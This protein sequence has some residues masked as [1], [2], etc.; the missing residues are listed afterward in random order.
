MFSIFNKITWNNKSK[1]KSEKIWFET[2]LLF[3]DSNNRTDKVVT[4]TKSNVDWLLSSNEDLVHKSDTKLGTFKGLS[5]WDNLQNT[6]SVK[7]DNKK[8]VSDERKSINK[9]AISLDILDLSRVIEINAEIRAVEAFDKEMRDSKTGHLFKKIGWFFKRSFQRMWRDAWIDSQMNR[10]IEEIEN[11][12]NTGVYTEKSLRDHVISADKWI[13]QKAYLS[14][15]E[16]INNQKAADDIQKTIDEWLSIDISD[17]AN[18]KSKI[19]E[20]KIALENNYP[21]ITVDLT[22]LESSLIRLEKAKIQLELDTIEAKLNILDIGHIE[23]WNGKRK[24]SLLVK[25][26]DWI[27]S[28]I[29]NY[30]LPD[31]MKKNISWFIQHPNTAAVVSAMLTRATVTALVG[32]SVIS[33]FLAPVAVWALAWWVLAAWRARR[34]MRDRTAQIDR[35]WALW[36]K[37]GNTKNDWLSSNKSHKTEEYQHSAMDLYNKISKFSNLD[38]NDKN[39]NAIKQEAL[40]SWIYYL[41]KHLVGREKNLNML[42]Y[43]TNKSVSSQHVETIILLNKLF[44]WLVSKFNSKELFDKKNDSEEALLTRKLYNEIDNLAEKNLSIREENESS[45]AL[46][47][48]LIYAWVASTVWVAVWWLLH[49]Y[50]SNQTWHVDIKWISTEHYP[51]NLEAH[52]HVKREFW[53]DNKT[54]SPKFD[55]TE[56]MLHTDKSWWWNVSSMLWKTAFTNNHS[57]NNIAGNDFLSHKI[58]AVV[59]PKIW[60]PSFVLPIDSNWNIQIPDSMKWSF[61]SRSFA[62]LE[63][64]KVDIDVNGTIHLNPIATV[65]WH[66]DM[67]FD[68]IFWVDD[69]ETITNNNDWYTIPF[70]WNKYHELWKTSRKEPV[71]EFIKNIYKKPD[72]ISKTEKKSLYNKNDNSKKL[73]EIDNTWDDLEE[74]TKDELKKPNPL[75]KPKAESYKSL[76]EKITVD[77]RW[78]TTKTLDQ[79]NKISSEIDKLNKDLEWRY[80]WKKELS[81]LTDD[82]IIY[83]IGILKNEFLSKKDEFDKEIKKIESEKVNKNLDSKYSDNID[84]LVNS[85]LLA[86]K[87]DKPQIFHYEWRTMIAV[88]TS[89]WWIIPFYRSYNWTSWKS[90]WK[91]YPF[92]WMSDE[93]IIKWT[94]QWLENWHWMKEL[95]DIQDKLN[96]SLNWPS[97]WDQDFYFYQDRHPLLKKWA[98]NNSDWIYEQEKFQKSTKPQFHNDW[99]AVDWIKEWVLRVTE[100]KFVL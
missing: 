74:V 54:P 50:G 42:Q 93:W 84:E 78:K 22:Q 55:N 15:E 90:K 33:W 12:L 92:F 14:H 38:T 29:N 6:K 64:W 71:W 60:W 80:L 19:S 98:I 96:S 61:N 57:F 97:K 67:L 89:S 58:Q 23:N 59:T 32:T 4:K 44:P 75:K 26:L 99:K 31:W 72:L 69:I 94:S 13:E 56:L 27:N 70:W 82:E 81:D 47:Q 87:Y 10:Y 35:R 43:D 40:V 28:G 76:V 68:K 52:S 51:D 62:F 11:W 7:W 25:M 21:E 34:E 77:S 37:T 18:R 66:W 16:V 95:K 86:T 3:K 17:V 39:Y 2:D 88:K 53:F 24:E 79:L 100:T 9:N 5:E 65:K 46:K 49:M 48:W 1:D 83:S 91:W 73:L 63:V 36:Y 85:W 20:L 30:R 45:Y 41:V 8:E